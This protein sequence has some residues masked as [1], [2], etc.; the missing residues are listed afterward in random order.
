MK[1]TGVQHHNGIGLKERYH[2]PLRTIYRRIKKEC[3]DIDDNFALKFAVKAMNDT[4]GPEGLVLLRPKKP[5][6]LFLLILLLITSSSFSFPFNFFF[7]VFF[8]F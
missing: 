8:S 1:L 5:P 6:F 7:L 4:V 2:G 3:P